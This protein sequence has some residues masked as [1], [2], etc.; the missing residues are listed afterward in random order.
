M[1]YWKYSDIGCKRILLAAENEACST[2][3]QGSLVDDNYF[4]EDAHRGDDVVSKLTDSLFDL[5]VIDYGLPGTPFPEIVDH[6]TAIL[7]FT[8]IVLMISNRKCACAQDVAAVA[9]IYLL[10]KPFTL[11][12]F[13]SVVRAVL[14][15]TGITVTT[16]PHR[17]IAT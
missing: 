6:H 12:E 16:R 17:K 14:G 7:C 2:R 1:D 9:P 15:N 11:P 5:C 13:G 10:V 3:L 4:I 8:P